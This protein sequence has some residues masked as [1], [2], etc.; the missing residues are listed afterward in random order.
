MV[1]C[2]ISHCNNV[3]LFIHNCAQGVFEDNEISCNRLA[4][5]W[6]KTGANPMMR[7]NDVH[8]GKDAGFFIFDGGMVRIKFHLF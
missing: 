1:R 6:V 5:I 8:H 4:G 3:G 7:R 2:N